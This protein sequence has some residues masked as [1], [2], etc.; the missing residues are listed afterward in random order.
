MNAVPACSPHPAI[1]LTPAHRKNKMKTDFKN[2]DRTVLEQFA[3]QVADENKILR[4]HRQ[5]FPFRDEALP[6]TKQGIFQKYHVRRTDGSDQPGGKHHGCRY[7]VIDL[8]HDIAAAPAMLA[9]ATAIRFTHPALALDLC[10]IHG[11]KL[12][13]LPACYYKLDCGCDTYCGDGHDARKK[14]EGAA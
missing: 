1:T 7:F 10:A 8:D 4:T 2:W 3:R 5:P 14:P 12:A 9:Y 6:A 13:R 11:Q